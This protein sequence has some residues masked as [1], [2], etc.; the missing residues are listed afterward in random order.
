MPNSWAFFGGHI[1]PGETPEQAVVREAREELQIEVLPRFFRRYEYTGPHGRVERFIFVQ[2]T[3]MTADELQPLQ[4]EGDRLGFFTLDEART[5]G[6]PDR[7][8]MVVEE[9][10]AEIISAKAQ[11]RARP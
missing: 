4:T 6:L 10:Y 7:Y 8:M 1:E 9:I 11:A 2:E 5:L 3:T